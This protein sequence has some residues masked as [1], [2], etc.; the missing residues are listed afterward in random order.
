MTPMDTI[1]S[2]VLISAPLAFIAGWVLSKAVFKTQ[3]NLVSSIKNQVFHSKKSKAREGA[4]DSDAQ[5]AE[6]Q[7]QLDHAEAR[8][9]K[10][11]RIFKVWRE[12]VQPIAH[13]FRRQRVIIGELRDEM[14]RR[15]AAVRRSEDA[16]EKREG[17][18]VESTV[19]SK[20]DSP[21]EPQ[22]SP[23]E[24]NCTSDSS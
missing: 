23:T 14:R 4:D 24:E 8:I 20:V 22:P 17:S 13:Q 21:V 12:R 19:E 11:R 5:I 18:K 1:V 10:S 9:L 16:G 3:T 6:L 2:T 7:R 15:D